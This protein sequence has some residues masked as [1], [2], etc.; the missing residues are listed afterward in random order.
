MKTAS[1]ELIALLDAQQFLMADLY[2]LSVATGGVY[3]FT[4]YD[5][6]L[7]V[8]GQIY[9][10]DG[11]IITR[12]EIRQSIGVE[13]DSLSVEI[14][15]TNTEAL[16][17]VPFMQLLHNGGLDGARL[18]LD[19][20][21]MDDSTPTDTSAG[22]ITLFEGRVA[23]QEFSRYEARLSVLSDLE[24]LDVQIPRNVYQPGCLNVLYDGGC[25]LSRTA[26]MATASAAEGSTIRQINCSLDQPAGYFT[27]GVAEFLTGANAG[28]RRTIRRHDSGSLL[29]SLSLRT[30][31]AVG[32]QL[33]I[34]AGCDKTKATCLG[35]FNNLARFRGFPFVPV[36]ETAV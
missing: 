27:Q 22:V 3:R 14:M 1:P 17:G 30:P 20:V 18:R 8:A 31:P 16:A 34:Y 21:F 13:V 29:L 9:V 32:D 26:F 19:R 7:T 12:S 10:A 15:A 23:E 25:G 24:L 6:P 36:P 28:V 2:T 4:N 35:R 11:L 33:R 5:V